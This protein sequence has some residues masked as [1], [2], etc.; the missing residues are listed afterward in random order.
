MLVLSFTILLFPIHI[1]TFILS[2]TYSRMCHSA[3][4]KLSKNIEFVN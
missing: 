1:Y 3:V 2:Y 4:H